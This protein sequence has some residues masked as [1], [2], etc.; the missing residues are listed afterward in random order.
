MCKRLRLDRIQS[1]DQNIDGVNRFHQHP[2]SLHNHKPLPG[3]TILFSNILISSIIY[4]FDLYAC[5]RFDD[6]VIL[7]TK[8]AYILHTDYHLFCFFFA[9]VLRWR[10]GYSFR[11]CVIAFLCHV[12]VKTE[13]GEVEPIVELF[14]CCSFCLFS[15]FKLEDKKYLHRS[16]WLWAMNV[17]TE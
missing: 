3:S 14:S 1:D 6:V 15:F 12:T 7:Y 4:S 17:H 9:R 10:F 2:K 8:S 13:A 16:I 11:R 5:L